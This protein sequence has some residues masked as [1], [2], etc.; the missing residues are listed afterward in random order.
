MFKPAPIFGD[1]CVLA[2]GRELRIF[3]Q[4]QEGAA[5]QAALLSAEGKLLSQGEGTAREGRFCFCLPA[6]DEAQT[7]CTLTLTCEGEERISRDVAI[8]LVFLAGGQ[9]N[10]EL[11][12]QNADEGKV[13]PETHDD[14]LVR[15]FNVPKRALRDE[16]AIRAEEHSHWETIRPGTGRD[17]S[18]VA[19]FFAMKLRRALNMPIGIIDC[20]WG[21]TSVTAWM[22]E[23]ALRRTSEGI[24]YLNSWQ[25]QA[26]DK[27]MQQFRAEWKAFEEGCAAWDR[28]ANDLRQQHPEYTQQQVNEIMGP[29]PWHPPAGPGSPYRPGGLCETMLKR[30]AP[31]SLTAALYYQGEDDAPKTEQYDQLL[32][33]LVKRWREL[34]LW[35]DLPFL[36]MQLP[37]WIDAGA[38]DDGTWA[39]LRIQQRRAQRM[40]G[41]S[42]LCC[43]I[44]CGEYNNIHPT[45]KRTPGERLADVY[46]K[47]IGLA[48]P[49]CPMAVRKACEGGQLRVSVNAPLRSPVEEPALFEVAGE[50]GRYVPAQAQ[51]QGCEILLSAPGVARPVAARYAHVAYAKVNVFGENGLPLEPFDLR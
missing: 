1:T 48:A 3:G 21:G 31:Y 41:N 35:D 14:P 43:I 29:Y 45:D 50:D 26:G 28:A 23:E 22:D 46:L 19:Y 42:E 32:M 39:R 30:V 47:R 12:L 44:D 38:Q 33:Q 10:M 27:T 7:G 36:N 18:A 37:M 9:S 25:Q 16:E 6:V 11:E 2:R 4:A 49:V 5:I 20:Y 40:I 8:G 34:F 13:L 17:M 15:Y 51:V 24:R